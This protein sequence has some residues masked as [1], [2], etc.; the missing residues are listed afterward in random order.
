MICSGPSQ[1]CWKDFQDR[2]SISEIFIF[3]LPGPLPASHK[4]CLG[5]AVQL[6]L[7]TRPVCLIQVPCV[8][9]ALHPAA[10]VPSPAL[11]TKHSYTASPVHCLPGC[12]SGCSISSMWLPSLLRLLRAGKT[13][14]TGVPQLHSWQDPF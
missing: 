1:P 12:S 8:S 11:G 10:T 9:Y 5:S 6:L 2:W 3:P 13:D 14:R 4:V 7:L